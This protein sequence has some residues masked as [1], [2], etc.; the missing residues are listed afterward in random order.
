[1]TPST[2]IDDSPITIGDWSPQNYERSFSGKVNLR[3]VAEQSMNVPTVKIAQKVGI[4]RAIYYAQEMGISTLVLDGP[5]NDKN[6]AT[7][8]GGLTKG[9]TRSNRRALTELLPTGASIR[10]RLPS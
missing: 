4:D 8:L 1:M 5:Q 10:R 7:A 3:T 6:L 9:V 2:I